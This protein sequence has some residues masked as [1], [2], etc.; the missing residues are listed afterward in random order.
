MTIPQ[1]DVLTEIEFRLEIARGM[2]ED[3]KNVDG[4]YD[5]G[6]TG[7]ILALMAVQELVKTMDF[8]NSGPQARLLNIL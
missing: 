1:P 2:F 4:E 3:G 8:T 5:H 6:R 7:I